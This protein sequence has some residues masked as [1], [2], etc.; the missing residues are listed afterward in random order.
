MRI[1]SGRDAGRVINLE[2]HPAAR[3]HQTSLRAANLSS[4]SCAI[5]SAA[6]HGLPRGHVC[7]LLLH[8]PINHPSQL[9]PV[10]GRSHVNHNPFYAAESTQGSVKLSQILCKMC[11]YVQHVQFSVFGVLLW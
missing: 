2:T 10:T 9:R 7:Q 3:L 4:P 11:N 8:S 6:A 1:G 5:L